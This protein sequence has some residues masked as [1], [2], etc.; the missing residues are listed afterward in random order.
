M[1]RAAR[2]AIEQESRN[3]DHV[4]V[5]VDDNKSKIGKSVNGVPIMHPSKALNKDFIES[6]N[7]GKVVVAIE[8]YGHISLEIARGEAVCTKSKDAADVSVDAF[9]AHR[10]FFGPLPP[11]AV[12]DLSPKLAVLQQWCPLPL[13]WAK[14]D[15]V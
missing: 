1:G 9:A 8:V 10:L 3:G 4:V 15:G 2:T 6:Q 13:Y 12:V 14:Q 7:I 5:M 11:S